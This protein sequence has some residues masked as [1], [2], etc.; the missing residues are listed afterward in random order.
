MITVNALSEVA[1]LMGDPARA[2]MLQLHDGWPRP[3][4]VGS[5]PCRR[6]DRADRVGPSRPH[7]RG[8]PARR[9]RAGP[10]PLLPPRLGRGGACHRIADGAGRRAR[11]A[12][13]EDRRVAAR[14]RSPLLPHLLRPSRRPGRHGGDRFADPARP[15]R[16][17]GRSATGRSP[18]RAS[19]S[20]SASASISTAP[21]RPT[22]VT[23]RA[24]ASTGRSGGRTSR[25]RW[26]RRS[27]TPSSRKAGPSACAAA[28]PCGSP[29]QVAGPLAATSALLSSLR[30]WP[31]VRPSP[32]GI[33]AICRGAQDLLLAHRQID[34]G[35]QQRA[36][37]THQLG[38]ALDPVAD[39]APAPRNRRSC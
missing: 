12:G 3:H 6:R 25:A 17:Q 36:G 5:R 31:K 1:A 37:L 27:P 24:S 10:Q 4:R 9:P 19:C 13:G 14:S 8:Q 33:L 29:I 28:A 26:A 39:A 15:S 38:P 34:V 22:A 2:A 20:A 32:D 30:A 21:S 11:P 7:G 16:A 18:S 35:E 23:S